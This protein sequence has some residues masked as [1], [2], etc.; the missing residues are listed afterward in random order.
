MLERATKLQR[1]LA[2]GII[3]VIRRVP[4]EAVEEVAQSL[5]NGGVSALEITVDSPSAFSIISKLSQKFKDT[6]I[7]GAGTVLD[8]ESARK[9]IESGA[10]FLLSPI[11]RK[12]VIVTASRYGKISVPG[13]MTPTEIITAIE[14]GADLVKIFPASTIGVQFIKDIKNVF[15]HIGLIPTGGVNLENV[16]LFIKAGASAVGVGGNLVDGNA[17]K[18]SNFAKIEQT[19]RAYIDAVAKARQ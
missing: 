5:I 18:T 19:A 11:L 17:I 1:L 9:A 10:E 13:V 2:S 7:V 12:D 14:W 16:S 3:A 15:P 6:A 4:E 8:G